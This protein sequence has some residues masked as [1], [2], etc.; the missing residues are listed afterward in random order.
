MAGGK[1]QYNIKNTT[2]YQVYLVLAILCVLSRIP[3]LDTFEIVSYDGTYYLG[4]AREMFGGRMPGS[5]PIGY[6]LLARIFFIVLRDY[7]LAGMAV[8]FVAGLGSLIVVYRLVAR[9]AGRGF[10]FLSAAGLAVNPLFVRY[11]LMT[12]SESAYIFWVLLG[13]LMFAEKRWLLFGL[14]MGMATITRPEAL[15]IAGVLGFSRIRRPKQAAAIAAAF[16]AVYA[17]NVAVLSVH[18][19]QLTVVS[20]VDLFGSGKENWK[21]REVSV[22]FE[23]RD[24]V[25]E[26][27]AAEGEQ[28]NIVSYYV[29]RI[30]REMKLLVVNAGPAVL[31]LALFAMRRRRYLFLVTGLMAFAINPLF[32]PR[33]EARFIL[34]YIPVLYALAGLAAA[35]LTRKRWRQAAAALFAASVV[36]LPAVNRAALLVPEDPLVLNTK[37]AAIELRDRVNPG[38]RA[39][40]RKPFFPFYTGCDYVE[41]P[42]APYENTMNFLLDEKVRFV[43]LHQPTI[44]QLRPI[45]RPLMY[46]RAVL[47]GE[48]RFRQVYFDPSGE[49]VLERTGM[50]DPLR[51]SRVTSGVDAPAMP[52]W[53]PD[54]RLIA[55]RSNGRE[56]GIFVAEIGG[57]E[58][59]RIADA[60]PVDDEISWSPDGARI[61]FADGEADRMS[62]YTVELASGV[63]RPVV[64]GEGNNVS[65][66]WSPTGGE[67]VFCSD[68]TGHREIWVNVLSTGQLHRL[69]TDGNNERP[70]ISPDARSI[71][72]IRKDGGVVI[73]DSVNR[74]LMRLPTPR[75]VRFAPSW[76]PDGRFL[77]VTAHDWGSLDIYLLRTDGTSVLLLTKNHDRDVM[78]AWS[79][80][81]SRIALVSERDA[82]SAGVWVV[83]GLRPYLERLA[84]P[85][86]VRVFVP[87]EF[88]ERHP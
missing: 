4:Q 74:R 84:S 21:L 82:E 66:S 86:N 47:N 8:S 71:A 79:P 81:G 2:D 13:L 35:G 49:M 15:L 41:I 22:Q 64:E 39:A 3:F 20:K 69:T 25:V 19:G 5:F 11:T 70:R 53:S 14:S 56:G 85:P 63:V 72:W 46:S 55:F 77:V 12:M 26:E 54:G 24:K 48:L 78:P 87:P 43:E 18:R 23:G 17:V 30:P 40:A 34:P 83:D 36:L 76:S 7:Q 45:L 88:G 27:I 38:D 1:R 58:V 33:E 10:A 6:P 73:M 62:I 50:D 67:I 59:R 31:L 65:P 57:E 80:D 61:A 44:H 37:P 9:F 51:W 28:R 52:E 42:L 16:L 32:T 29:R 75:R 60:K 68:R